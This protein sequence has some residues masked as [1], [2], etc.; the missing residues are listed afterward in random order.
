MLVASVAANLTVHQFLGF[1]PV[2]HMPPMQLTLGGEMAAYAALGI[3]AG[4]LAPLFLY[5]LDAARTP[6]ARLRWQRSAKLGLGAFW[7]RL[8][9]RR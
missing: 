2:Y 4:L 3:L 5:L 1:G 8:R 9:M 6:F 7:G